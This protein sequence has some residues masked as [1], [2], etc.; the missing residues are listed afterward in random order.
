MGWRLVF[1]TFAQLGKRWRMLSEK[2]DKAL[3]GKGKERPRWDTCMRRLYSSFGVPM[4]TMYVK[5]HF[6]T[7]SLHMVSAA[8]FALV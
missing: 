2:Y 7:D 5:E 1:S 6:D 3:T 8:V 4:S